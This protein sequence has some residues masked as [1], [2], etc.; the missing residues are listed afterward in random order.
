MPN[1]KNICLVWIHNICVSESVFNTLRD[2][3]VHKL[4]INDY[5]HIKYFNDQTRPGWYNDYLTTM[6]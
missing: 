2:W 1:P 5:D 3:Y 6:I 4:N